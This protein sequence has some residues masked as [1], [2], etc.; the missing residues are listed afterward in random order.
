[1]LIGSRTRFPFPWIADVSMLLLQWDHHESSSH[2]YWGRW[3]LHFHPLAFLLVGNKEKKT[4]R[5]HTFVII[6][7]VFG[8]CCM[9]TG[10]WC[11]LLLLHTQHITV[12]W[13]SARAL[14]VEGPWTRTELH[15]L[16]L[17]VA[18][19]HP[20]GTMLF[21]RSPDLNPGAGEFRVSSRFRKGSGVPPASGLKY[22]SNGMNFAV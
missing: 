20:S 8:K 9:A 1:M 3:K 15:P 21:I 13:V 10:I 6:Y 12:R 4:K 7:L 22:N 14:T 2:W 19:P 17:G 18:D 16:P 11:V 5:W